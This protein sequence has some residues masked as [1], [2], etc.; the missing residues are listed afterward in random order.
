MVPVLIRPV[1]RAQGSL[2]L[3]G[4]VADSKAFQPVAGLGQEPVAA[5][6]LTVQA[7]WSTGE[8][9]EG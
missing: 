1:H 9:R 2:E 3:Q 4:A 8:L 7:I 5:E 6:P